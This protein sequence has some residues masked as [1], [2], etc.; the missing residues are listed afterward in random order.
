MSSAYMAYK[1]FPEFDATKN[2]DKYI[3]EYHDKPTSQD[4]EG[5]TAY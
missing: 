2:R 1:I 5:A 3:M 4:L